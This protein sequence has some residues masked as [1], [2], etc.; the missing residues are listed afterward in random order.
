MGL[1]C[2]KVGTPWFNRSPER[3]APAL[4][5]V[6]DNHKTDILLTR[7]PGC[8]SF[9]PS[10]L[11]ARDSPCVTPSPMSLQA[12]T[13]TRTACIQVQVATGA[14]KYTAYASDYQQSLT[15]TRTTLLSLSR[16]NGSHLPNKS[17]HYYLILSSS[18]IY[19][20]SRP[21]PKRLNTK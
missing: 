18:D 11:T 13:A 21:L 15:Q 5:P 17:R 12:Q 9:T 7:T 3:L 20:D 6:D 4:A 19:K 16:G 14:L 10:L 8:V 2:N 1:N